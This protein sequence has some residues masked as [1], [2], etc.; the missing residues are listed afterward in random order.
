MSEDL[1]NVDRAFQVAWIVYING[2]E[3]PALSTS[4]AY[5]VWQIPECEVTLIPDPVLQRLGAEDRIAVQVFYC[6]YWQR[7]DNPEFRLMFD[8]EIVAW[9][10]VNVQRGRALSFTCIDYIQIFTQ[11]FFFFMSNVDDIATGTSAEECGVGIATVNTPG[12]GTI[13][14]YSLFSEGLIS[15]E[16]EGGPAPQAPI[17]KRPIDFVY[18]VVRGLTQINAPNRSVPASNFFAPWTRRT[19]FHRRFVALPLLEKPETD[20]GGVFPILRAV[21]ADF[22]VSAVARLAQSIGSSGSIWDMLQQIMQTLMM[23]IAMLPTAA[24]A[25]INKFPTN[26]SR[27]FRPRWKSKPAVLKF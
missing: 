13:Y 6:D 25:V 3:C 20:E 22:A 10:Y 11:V 16:T 1:V 27:A 14:P 15:V 24:A 18:N 4:T 21:R 7:P 12:F 19:K 8:G 5:G 9:S 17:I 26:D 23:E 2:L